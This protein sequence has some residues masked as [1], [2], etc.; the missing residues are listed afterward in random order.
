[1]AIQK[2]KFDWVDA[3]KG[4]ALLAILLN[5]FVESF[6][7]GPW[8]SNPN[9]N[10]PE[11]SVRMSNLF[12]SEGL[13]PVRIIH[14]IG[15]LGDMGPG[16]FI[17][18]SGLVLTI[19]ALNNPLYTIEFYK[20]RLL[21]IFPLYIGI[22]IFI[23]IVAIAYF[24]WNIDFL[25]IKTL[26]SLAGLRFTNSLFFYINPSWW[27]IWTLIQ[28]YFIFPFLIILLQKSR[29]KFFLLL[30]FTITILSRLAGIYG[31]SLSSN[32]YFWMT[33]L[34]AGTRLF[35][36]SIGMFLGYAIFSNRY[37]IN[38]LLKK[39]KSILALSFLIYVI[40]FIA[41]WTYL[42]SVF[43]N[44]LI[45]LG[46][47]GIFYAGY[48]LFFKKV[49]TLKTPLI[50][51]G[52]NSFGIFL[53]HQPFLMYYS[54]I[55]SGYLKVFV[56][57]LSLAASFLLGNIFEKMV[58]KMV[59]FI[60]P[61]WDRILGIFRGKTGLFLVIGSILTTS[62]IGLLVSLEFRINPKYITLLFLLQLIYFGFLRLFV[63]ENLPY[64]IN[65]LIDVVIILTGAIIVL[66]WDW[67]SI[68]WLLIIF[69]YLIIIAAKNFTHAVRVFVSLTT[70][71]LV[72][73]VTEI[74]LWKNKPL[75]VG[76]WGEY[77]ALQ[78]DSVTVYSLIPNRSTQLRYNNY[79]YIVKTN[80]LGFASSGIDLTSKPANEKRIMI[81][82]DAFSMPEGMEYE[83]SYPFLLENALRDEYKNLNINV[84]NAGVTGYGPIEE[85]AQLKKFIDTLKPDVVVNQ[86]FVNEYSD[87][88]DIPEKKQKGIGFN[89][90]YTRNSKLTIRAQT[91]V[92]ALFL[93]K[94]I[95]GRDNKYR[96][97]KSLL[98]LY[99]KKSSLF[100]DSVQTKMGSY[101]DLM[102]DLCANKNSEYVIMYVPGQIEVSKPAHISYFP[103]N[104]N[105]ND[106]AKFDFNLPESIIQKL[107]G[108]KN[109]KFLNTKEYL[110]NYTTQ[111]LYFEESWHW[112]KEGHRAVAIFLADYLVQNSLISNSSIK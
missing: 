29:I 20:K 22:H 111:P 67:L 45:T 78:V 75:E 81:I 23:L 15:W 109:I 73:G 108:N 72:I 74:F 77:P 41:S 76:R 49:E 36:F 12:P 112:N 88:N 6:N 79:D 14:F 54:A 91:P 3:L 11:F 107:C 59:N 30:T 19:S 43:S 31:L 28:L 39:G 8:F 27:F 100:S 16:V 4:F 90:K 62:I 9:Y 85:Y 32:L 42:G 98:N 99:E 40:G 38:E 13:L 24:K 18:I 44:I 92:H 101:L 104:E 68:Y 105:I 21:R 57:V 25:S 69:S 64:L 1:M 47:S 89:S 7:S 5:H 71:I 56:L 26:L 106:T 82:G 110:K 70:L 60:I 55:Y 37:N 58:N 96:Y 61:F 95:T 65:S 84:I 53:I 86:F 17:F 63:R 2:I 34:F 50:W 97:Y 103:Y 102:S 83:F 52:K 35:E 51:T 87:I 46:L 10:W 93:I 94:D 33:G 66:P 80:S 48:E